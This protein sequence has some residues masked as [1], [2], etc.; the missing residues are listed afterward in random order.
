MMAMVITGFLTGI[1][2]G[3]LFR[4]PMAGVYGTIAGAS[5][6]GTAIINYLNPLLVL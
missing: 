5:L 6:A 3:V 1:V 4:D 2:A